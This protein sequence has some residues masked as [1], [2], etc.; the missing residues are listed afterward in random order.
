MVFQ[1]QGIFVRRAVIVA[2][3]LFATFFGT[4]AQADI[5]VLDHE[6]PSGGGSSTST[7]R[8]SGSM[9]CSQGYI[10]AGSAW[11][12]V[13]LHREGVGVVASGQKRPSGGTAYVGPKAKVSLSVPCTPGNYRVVVSG[14]SP[15]V[16]LYT[17][18][19]TSAWVPISCGAPPPPP[20]PTVTDQLT[21]TVGEDTWGMVRGYDLDLSFG[22]VSPNMTGDGK[23]YRSVI[24]FYD[25]DYNAYSGVTVCGFSSDPGGAWLTSISA[26]G[27][28]KMASAGG[29]WYGTSGT[30][31]GCGYWSFAGIMGFPASAQQVQVSIAHH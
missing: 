13:D 12:Y 17:Q 26:G 28:T 5:C 27:V 9:E 8:A 19:G 14:Y 22:A 21:L 29:Y 18:G 7:V 6:P 20:P 24:E 31:A 10:Y 1:A 4:R 25:W 2:A 16:Q 30:Y 15:Y 23:T 3:M 11:V